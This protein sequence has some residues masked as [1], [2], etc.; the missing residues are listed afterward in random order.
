MISF[1]LPIPPSANRLNFNL[2]AER[3]GGRA[4][5]KEYREWI[6]E[7]QLM[8]MVQ[9]A[10]PIEGQVRIRIE[11]SETAGIDLSNC[12]KPVED[13]L[14]RHR[15][16]KDDRKKFVRGHETA[17]SSDIEGVRVTITP[18]KGGE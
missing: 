10:R 14:V 8:L 15:V 7:A 6:R 9:R 13:L 4:K 5:T 11:L 2:P 18:M 1:D 12:V 16:I 3:G 17:W